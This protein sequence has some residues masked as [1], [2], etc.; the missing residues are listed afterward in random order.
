MP[1]VQLQI[2]RGT[3]AE[4]AAATGPLAEGE[5]GYDTNSRSIKVGDGSTMWSS[6]GVINVGSTGST[7]PSGASGP[8]GPTGPTGLSGPTGPSGPAGGPPGVTGPSG[9]SGPVGQ[10]VTGPTGP[11]AYG[12]GGVAKFTVTSGEIQTVDGSAFLNSI[13]TW[14]VSSTAVG[15]VAVLTYNST[16]YPASGPPPHVNGTLLYYPNSSVVLPTGTV[17]DAY[18]GFSIPNS[19]YVAGAPNVYVRKVSSNWVLYIQFSG[20][21]TLGGT[22]ASNDGAGYGVYIYL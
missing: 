12:Q 20:S 5:L 1:Y 6:L 19:T 15:K 2:R 3:A 10:G 13:G 9:P 11:A 18:K 22:S 14:S 8:T 16:T 17:T 21:T 7:G 4:W